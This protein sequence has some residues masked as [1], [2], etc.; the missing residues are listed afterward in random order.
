LSD[1]TATS[2]RSGSQPWSI[3]TPDQTFD[4]LAAGQTLTALYTLTLTDSQAASVSQAVTLVVTGS[5]DAPVITVDTGNRPAASLTEANNTL[6][7]LGTLSVTDLDLTN[8]V[9]ASVISVAKSEHPI[10]HHQQRQRP[11]SPDDGRYQPHH[12]RHH[13]HAAP[14]T[15]R[16]I[17]GKEPFDYLAKGET[18]TL[19]YTL[20]V[21]DT[22]ST[23]TKDVVITVKGTNDAPLIT[24][25]NQNIQSL[26][27]TNTTL[28]TSGSFS[29]TDVDY[30][31]VVSASNQGV[32]ITSG[33]TNG[34]VSSLDTLKNMLT[35]GP[36]PVISN[37]A[38]TGTLNWNFNSGS[39]AFDH[40]AV[41]ESLTLTYAIAATDLQGI[42]ANETVVI[43]LNGTNDAPTIRSTAAN[44]VISGGFTESAPAG[45]SA[46]NTGDTTRPHHHQRRRHH[47]DHG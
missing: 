8:T 12:Q 41:G 27:E 18:L 29:V 7:A 22:S 17:P 2:T 5:N 19:T 38:T 13:D 21:T 35:V 33:V 45:G 3:N 10:G 43:T 11:V 31:D 16:S 44:H 20:G 24:G 37:T 46:L 32:T 28:T 14:C 39:E 42:R 6:T 4:F 15:G 30:S 9:A 1:S 40:L 23:A 34:L 26:T 36:V 47:H 25:I